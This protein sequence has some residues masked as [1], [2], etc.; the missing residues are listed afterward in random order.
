MDN[1][2]NHHGLDQLLR[3]IVSLRHPPL[4]SNSISSMLTLTKTSLARR[5]EAYKESST[6]ESSSRHV[7]VE[8]D[9]R[10][11]SSALQS[12]RCPLP[13]PCLP[14]IATLRVFALY[15]FNIRLTRKSLHLSSSTYVPSS[16]PL[17]AYRCSAVLTAWLCI[18]HAL[19]ASETAMNPAEPR[20]LLA[21]PLQAASC[22]TPGN[23][24]AHLIDKSQH[25]YEFSSRYDPGA[26]AVVVCFDIG[27][28]D[29]CDNILQKVSASRRRAT[30]ASD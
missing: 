14:S 18:K 12:T 16:G 9:Y 8:P 22:R 2:D 4:A 27:S 21:T 3:S 11:T 20:C 5:Q 24:L 30:S 13:G 10:G 28:P 1:R 26:H 17:P 6:G 23:L 19:A 7:G 29:S 15:P 25:I